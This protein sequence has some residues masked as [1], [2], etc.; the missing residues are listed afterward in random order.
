M[1]KLFILICVLAMLLTLTGVAS[2]SPPKPLTFRIDGHTTAIQ[3]F[4][5][6]PPPGTYHLTSEG[7]VSGDITGTFV[8][9]E[10][11]LVYQEVK[12]VGY[13]AI[14]TNESGKVFILF[15]GGLDPGGLTI[16]GHFWVTRGTGAYRGLEGRQG[17]YHGIPDPCPL[18]PTCPGFYVDFTFAH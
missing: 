5:P 7:G 18:D 11:L 6:P 9:D 3:P 15:V 4:P 12:N 1:K 16:S 17:G 8:M 14:T 10:C 13:I 2:A